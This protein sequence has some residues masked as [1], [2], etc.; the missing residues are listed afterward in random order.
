MFLM[1][2]KPFQR[3]R[4][5]LFT[6]LICFS[7]ELPFFV[8]Q[9]VL[10]CNTVLLKKSTPF[11]LHS[12][13]KHGRALLLPMERRTWGQGSCS[14]EQAVIMARCGE[15]CAHNLHMG[16]STSDPDSKAR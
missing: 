14:E 4:V 10:D 2:I 5:L 15:G 3:H 16:L 11:Q 7:Q 1:V 9:Q 13:A 12:R 8:P 6:F